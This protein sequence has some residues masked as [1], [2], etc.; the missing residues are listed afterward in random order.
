MTRPI[1]ALSAVVAVIT[2]MLMTATV[3][4]AQAYSVLYSFCTTDVDTCP[5]GDYPI[6][7][8]Q[9]TD[10]NFYGTTS[11]G[12][13]P[14]TAICSTSAGDTGCGTVFKITPSGTLT[15]LHWFCAR[16]SCT[17]GLFP[18][19]LIQATNG[20]FYGGTERGGSDR[21]GTLFEINSG[22]D[23][24]TLYDFCSQPNCADGVLPAV[25]LMQATDG[26]LYGVAPGGANEGGTVFKI[27]P[28]GQFASV[29]NFCSQ[30]NCTDGEGPAAA[31]IQTANG[32][33]YGTT[34]SGGANGGGTIFRISASGQLTTLYNFCSQANCADGSFPSTALIQAT[35]GDFYGTTELG[36]AGDSSN[37]D[38]AQGAGCGTIFKMTPRGG[39]TTLYSFDG[40]DGFNPSTLI[41]GSNGVFYGT[42][43]NGGARRGGTVFEITPAGKFA[44]L[45][46]FCSQPKCADGVKAKSLMQATNGNLYGT[47]TSG[48]TT[49]R[50]T[51]FSIN[52]GLGPF[53]ALRASF[54]VVGA[55]VTLLGTNLTGTTSVTF[56]GTSATF[57]VNATGTA[58]TATVPAGA[59]TGTV[60]VV[61]PNGSLNSNVVCTVK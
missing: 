22:G 19:P 45:Y 31:L 17:D 23:L 20:D 39:L 29:Y 48:G 21:S 55:T 14:E 6:S 58:I 25:A 10:G 12:G 38:N 50:G 26:D 32:E 61:T 46:S 28:G 49:G 59:T 51:L 24:T 36:G 60:Q 4:R 35:N 34:T 53:V 16:Q 41:R 11:F 44:T 30:P 27:S 8:I 33:F 43:F 3:A 54:G 1:L 40:T 7:L 52:V 2:L 5:G 15:T 56:N 42:T 47:D 13:S 37:C 57:T 9:A 18:T